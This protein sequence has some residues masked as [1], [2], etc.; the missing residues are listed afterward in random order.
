MDTTYRLGGRETGGLNILGRGAGGSVAALAALN[1][2][3]R[4][5]EPKLT[6]FGQPKFGD[7]EFMR[8]FDEVCVILYHP[9]HAVNE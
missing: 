8:F 3:L 9:L 7:A 6:T 4:G 1:F 2:S 5:W